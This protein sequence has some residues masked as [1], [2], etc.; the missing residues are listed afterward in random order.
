MACASSIFLL[1]PKIIRRVLRALLKSFLSRLKEC[2]F[3][4]LGFSNHVY[5][6]SF[7]YVL[8]Y[9]CSISRENSHINPPWNWTNYKPEQYCAILGVWKELS[10]KVTLVVLRLEY[11]HCDTCFSRS[12]IIDTLLCCD[13]GFIGVLAILYPFFFQ[14]TPVE[15]KK[16]WEQGKKSG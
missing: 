9:Y 13:R 5:T 7:V 16:K 11:E 6:D 12:W 10:I 14:K 3:L 1:S 8:I 2:W 15:F 4:K